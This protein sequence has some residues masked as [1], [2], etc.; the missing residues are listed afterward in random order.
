MSTEVEEE[1]PWDDDDAALADATGYAVA[2]EAPP[3]FT[4]ADEAPTCRCGRPSVHESGWCGVSP[5]MGETIACT[6][7]VRVDGTIHGRE[8]HKAESA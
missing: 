4:F 1:L 5:C 2:G 3:N 7:C 8:H 6:G